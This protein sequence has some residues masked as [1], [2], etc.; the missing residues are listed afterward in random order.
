MQK[1]NEVETLLK[2]EEE[3]FQQ[4]SKCCTFIRKYRLEAAVVF[5]GACAISGAV[6]LM[7]RLKNGDTF[8][9]QQECHKCISTDHFVWNTTSNVCIN[10]TSTCDYIT[11]GCLSNAEFCGAPECEAMQPIKGLSPSPYWLLAASS[12]LATAFSAVVNVFKRRVWLPL[13]LK[14]YEFDDPEAELSPDEKSSAMLLS[15]FGA[16]DGYY[17]LVL[18]VLSIAHFVFLITEVT[19]NPSQYTSTAW[20]R[21]QTVYSLWVNSGTAPL[22]LIFVAQFPAFLCA[23]LH[24]D[25]DLMSD[26]SEFSKYLKD[27]CDRIAF[28]LASIWAPDGLN[29]KNE[30]KSYFGHFLLALPL[31]PFFVTHILPA[32]VVFLPCTLAV[33][34]A[35]VITMIVILAFGKFNAFGK[36]RRPSEGRVGFMLLMTLGRTIGSMLLMYLFQAFGTYAILLYDGHSWVDCIRNEFLFR[37]TACYVNA[38]LNELQAYNVGL[39]GLILS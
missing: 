33:V 24:F 37:S 30:A 6:I 18:W 25:D 12:G 21:Y 38:I 4:R 16:M 32:A 34:L 9:W 13:K 31:V 27:L 26:K 11:S 14:C 23:K 7:V 36:F 19:R 1:I 15:V 28:P 20:G 10:S 29:K 35:F 17:Y 8:S 22:L 5:T 3:E 2:N 39:V